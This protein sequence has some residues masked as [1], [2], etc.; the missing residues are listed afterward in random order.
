MMCFPSIHSGRTLSHWLVV[1][2]A[3]A[4]LWT[5]ANCIAP[6]TMSL[7]QPIQTL[8]LTGSAPHVALG[9]PTAALNALESY[10]WQVAK[11]AFLRLLILFLGCAAGD[12]LVAAFGHSGGSSS[13]SSSRFSKLYRRQRGDE[14]Q[15]GLILHNPIRMQQQPWSQLQSQSQQTYWHP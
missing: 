7:P 15:A 2:V 13:A 1:V 11:A 9:M 12:A 3:T 8:L 14:L 5:L 6:E 4:A 10:P